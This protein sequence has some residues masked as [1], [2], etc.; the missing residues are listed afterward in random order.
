MLSCLIHSAIMPGGL[1]YLQGV[2]FTLLVPCIVG[3]WLPWWMTGGAPLAS[4]LWQCGWLLVLAGALVY[5]LCLFSF[6]EAGG[7]PAPFFLRSLRHILGAEPPRLVRSQLYRYS[8][9][10]MYL[11]VITS[12]FGIAMVHASRNAA[13]YAFGLFLTF[14]L[15]VT[16]IEEPHLKERDPRSFAEYTS[17][18]PRWIGRGQKT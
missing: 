5:F 2:M 7:T 13:V 6:L 4:G 15:V 3:G 9:N 1:V 18:V 16:L 14:H 10:P 17:R 8:R 12:S 11:G